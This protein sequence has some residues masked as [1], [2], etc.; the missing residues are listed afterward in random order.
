VAEAEPRLAGWALISLV[1]LALAM[2][3]APAWLLSL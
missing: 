2:G 1:I 3:L